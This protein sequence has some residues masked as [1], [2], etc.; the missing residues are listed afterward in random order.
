MALYG[1]IFHDGLWRV[2]EHLSHI[3]VE[4]LHTIAL[5]E[6]E[7]SIACGLSDYIQRSTLALGNLTYMFDVLLVDEQTHTLLTLVGNDLLA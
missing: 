5:L 6:R 1:I 4:R 2:S 7:V 3:E